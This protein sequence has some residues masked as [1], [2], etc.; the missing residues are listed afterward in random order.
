MNYDCEWLESH[1][2]EET[3][4][5]FPCEWAKQN[6]DKDIS[7]I[8]QPFPCQSLY[9]KWH[10]TKRTVLYNDG[11]FIINELSTN[12]EKNTKAHGTAD[13]VYDPLDATHDYV[14]TTSRST[15]WASE[16]LLI[17]SAEFGSKVAPTSLAYWFN[18]CSNLTSLNWNNFDG[19]NVTTTKS[20]FA[21]AGIS[22]ASAV[23]PPMPNL[24]NM[25]WTF[26]G[27]PN[28]LTVDLSQVGSNKINNTD[29]LI[30]NSLQVT[31]VDLTGLSG[32]VVNCAGM[33]A[34]PSNGTDVMALTIVYV[35]SGL[36]FSSAT[37]VRDMFRRCNNLVGGKGTTWDSNYITNTYARIDN[38]PTAPGYFTS[39]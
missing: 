35:D 31:S 21:D 30:S 16:E 33:F 39:K 9:D 14:F 24:E 5:D 19:S 15:P 38:P 26:S 2:D 20:F 11:T 4:E 10:A 3:P 27:C 29:G 28:L 7:E 8:T 17:K 32:N 37:N 18:H 1:I 22:S 34:A 13:Y 36:D 6:W 23:F 12:I 25:Q